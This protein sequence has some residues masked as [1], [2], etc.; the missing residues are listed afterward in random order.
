MKRVL[1][2]ERARRK[3]RD[4]WGGNV[5]TRTHRVFG[6]FFEAEPDTQLEKR[7]RQ[8]TQ[9]PAKNRVKEGTKRKQTSRLLTELR[10]NQRIM[11]I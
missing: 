8:T 1:R 6:E 5:L 4:G 10:E 2:Q 3:K 9:L 7:N 11:R